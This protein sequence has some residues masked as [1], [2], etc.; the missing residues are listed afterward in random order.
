MATKLK[1][2]VITKVALCDEGACSAAHIQLFKRREGG[3]NM[4]FEEIMKSL[5]PEQQAIVKAKMAETN[6]AAEDKKAGELKTQMD[7][8]EADNTK[9]KDDLAKART[10]DATPESEADILKTLDPAVRAI[11]EKSRLQAQAAEESVKKMREEQINREA[12]AKAKTVI[13]LGTEAEL[14]DLYKSLSNA[15]AKLCEQTFT[16]LT[17][18]NTLIEK[19]AMFTEAGSGHEGNE[20]DAWDKVEKAASEIAKTRNITKA[21]AISAVMEEQPDLYKAYIDEQENR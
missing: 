19:S 11:V 14:A 15:D 18:A 9:L 17:K 5:T 10:S 6:K 12:I 16:L 2:L 8:L 13:N 1:N 21:K 3:N 20:V 4:N 7:T